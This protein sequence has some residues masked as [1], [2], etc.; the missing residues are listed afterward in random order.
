MTKGVKRIGKEK[1]KINGS[2]GTESPGCWIISVDI[3]ITSNY[4]SISGREIDGEL[5]SSRN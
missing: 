1:S 5:K 3:K 2:Q 4:D